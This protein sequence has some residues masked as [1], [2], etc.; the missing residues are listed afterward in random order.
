MNTD[1]DAIRVAVKTLRGIKP[2]EARII[3]IKNTLE[4]N[5]IEVSETLMD[6]VISHPRMDLCGDL[7][8]FVFDPDGNLL[9]K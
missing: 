6:Q 2:E 1:E 7:A 8:P 4:L 9:T 5:R 3:R